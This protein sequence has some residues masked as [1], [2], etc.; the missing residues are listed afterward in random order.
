MLL[1]PGAPLCSSSRRPPACRPPSLLPRGAA[2]LLAG[3]GTA[4]GARGSR[5][6]PAF[7]WPQSKPGSPGRRCDPR[8]ASASRRV[9]HPASPPGGRAEQRSCP[10]G[11]RQRSERAPGGRSLKTGHGEQLAKGSEAGGFMHVDGPVSV[12]GGPG[13]RLEL[14]RA[15]QRLSRERGCS[16][17]PQPKPTPQ[18]GGQT[19]I[20]KNQTRFFSFTN[21]AVERPYQHSD[22]SG[23][24]PGR[25]PLG[26]RLPFGDFAARSTGQPL[27]REGCKSQQCL[28]EMRSLKERQKLH[29]V[30]L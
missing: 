28:S 3:T 1:P 20:R 18:A 7:P 2:P 12:L 19:Q 9:S 26:S 4:P 16:S 13:R 10:R 27:S 24:T 23:L 21:S 25:A 22:L 29:S 15:A 11:P 14:P 8:P 17:S 6:P 30:A 5:H